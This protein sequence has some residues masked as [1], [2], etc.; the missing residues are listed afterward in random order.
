MPILLKKKV[1]NNKEKEENVA[2]IKINPDGYYPYCS[3]CYTEI[4]GTIGKFC[5]NCGRRFIAK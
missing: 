1:Q 3:K 5:P 4:D 2:E